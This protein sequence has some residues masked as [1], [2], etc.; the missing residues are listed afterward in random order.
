MKKEIFKIVAQTEPVFVASKKQENGQLAKCYIR[1]K[2]LG[3]EYEDEYVCAVF[4]NLAQ[5]KF[6]KDELVVAALQF[7]THESNGIFY[8]DVVANEIV[9]LNYEQ[10]K[11]GE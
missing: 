3:G 6:H 11:N 9:K 10:I 5:C 1:L 7:R 8:Q 2:E 4:G